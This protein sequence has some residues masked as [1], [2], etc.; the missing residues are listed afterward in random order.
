[1]KNRVEK[2]L[3]GYRSFRKKFFQDDTLLFEQLALSQQ[4]NIMVVACCDSRVDPSVLLQAN[5]GD[6][7]VVRTIASVVPEKNNKA[8]I[9]VHAALEFAIKGL[10]VE[11]VILLGHS[12]CGG[13]K[14]L[15][16][17]DETYEHVHN[18]MSQINIDVQDD[19]ALERVTKK[20][21]MQS[22]DNCF[23]FDFIKRAVE[24]N[25]LTIHQWYFD[26]EKGK[27]LACSDDG[28]YHDL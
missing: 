12:D 15:F 4:P 28:Q 18:W 17:N 13:A 24:Q 22:H 10:C 26:I 19:D 8:G 23:S 6:L 1:M 5:P 7:F 20:I 11:H 27:L 2:I 3:D 16:K 21:L 14:I 25:K 9:S